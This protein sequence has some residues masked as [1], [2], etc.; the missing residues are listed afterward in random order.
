VRPPQEQF[1]YEPQPS[2]PGPAAAPPERFGYQPPQQVPAPEPDPLDVLAG[3]PPGYM[4]EIEL[5]GSLT[6]SG[7]LRHARIV[8]P[9]DPSG[10]R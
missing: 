7:G 2:S 3:L 1:G 5:S 9:D 8:P 10:R 4:I 6:I